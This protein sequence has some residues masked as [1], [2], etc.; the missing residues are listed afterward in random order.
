ME[1]EGRLG[2]SAGAPLTCTPLLLQD[3]PELGG[4]GSAVLIRGARSVGGIC[5]QT[6]ALRI[7]NRHWGK[8]SAV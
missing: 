4:G 5:W 3:F 2:G 7:V 8:L 1:P 6:D